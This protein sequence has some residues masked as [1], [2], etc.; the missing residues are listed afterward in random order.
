MQQTVGAVELHPWW[1]ENKVCRQLTGSSPLR[2]ARVAMELGVSL[3]NRIGRLFF[4]V[5]IVQGWVSSNHSECWSNHWAFR[6]YESAILR[7]N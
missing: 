7:S 6:L 3:P 2:W 4:A 1:V 5:L